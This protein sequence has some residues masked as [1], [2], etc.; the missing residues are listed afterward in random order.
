[1]KQGGEQYY[2]LLLEE[3]KIPSPFK[4]GSLKELAAKVE[5]LLGKIKEEIK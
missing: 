3:A 1:M 4:D 2:D 5:V